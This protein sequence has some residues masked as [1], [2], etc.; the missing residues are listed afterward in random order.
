M[1]NL[2]PPDIKQ[3]YKYARYNRI[4][5]FWAGGCILAIIGVTLI[6]GYGVFSMD[7][8]LN[9]YQSAV[10][11]SQLKLSNSQNTQTV[12]LVANIS[13][14]LN[15]MLKVLSKEVLFSDLLTRLGNITPSN[16]IL[17]NLSIAQD[18]S[19]IDITAETSNYNAATQ[20][21]VNLTDPAN[22]VFSKADIVSITCASGSQVTNANYPCTADI[23]AMFLP[24][25]PFLFINSTSQKAQ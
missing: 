18:E 8:S 13:N 15:L 1:I 17:T 4:L 14:N 25:N 12:K 5:A 2:L 24:N 16:V 6:T 22:Q 11:S 21:Q 9:N 20:L 23:R 3:S 10:S 19:A 7:H